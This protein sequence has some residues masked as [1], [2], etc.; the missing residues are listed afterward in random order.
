MENSVAA[1]IAAYRWYAR[2]PR[3]LP[4]GAFLLAAA[5]TAL[6][7]FAI[8]RV[9][10]QAAREKVAQVAE[11]VNVALERRISANSAYLLAGAAYISDRETVSPEQFRRFTNQLARD[12]DFHSAEGI[13]WGRMLVRG[14]EASFTSAMRAQGYPDY[15][16]VPAGGAGNGVRVPVT[17]LEPETPR[18][19][20][21]IG[22]DLYSEPVR[23]A[24]MDLAARNNTPT[25][26]GKL[27]LVQDWG[28]GNRPGFIIF[29][30]VFG[31]GGEGSKLAGFIYS[32]FT[33]QNVLNA[34]LTGEQRAGYSIRLFDGPPR[35]DRL[36]AQVGAAPAGGAWRLQQMMIA[37]RQMTLGVEAPKQARLS[38]LSLLTLLFG[39]IAGG[40]ILLLVRLITRQAIADRNSLAWFE[41]QASIRNSL[42]RELNHR[43][44]NTLANVL[45]IISLTRRRAANLDDFSE[46]LMG[47]ISALSATHDL[48][49]QS[50][51]GTTPIRAV[52][53]AEL[54]PYIGGAEGTVSTCG[55]DIEIAPNDA[56][57]LG[58]ALHELATNASKYGALSVPSGTV[59]VRWDLVTQGLA[60][61][62]W[63][64]Q[65]GPPVA[66][67]NRRGFGTELIE[68]IVAHELGTAVDL[69]FDPGGV[70]CTLLVPVRLP[71][72]FKIRADPS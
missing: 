55:I 59:E 41:E 19:R 4:S 61:V 57:S 20:V 42:T 67:E 46:A 37:G 66:A 1:R 15:R 54:A 29:M 25:A 56:L 47:R 63:T 34:A 71:V 5:L 69:R 70:N 53:D 35:T 8:E 22:F 52:V 64:E 62:V 18:N 33:A 72:N 51:W 58:L 36:L 24:A 14:D 32:A 13:G 60:R 38:N 6:S 9:E 44:K 27:V 2:F 49:T 17:F 45:S 43:V 11:A 48:L 28:M 30:P 3:A 40:L 68:K 26:T 50:E 12:A 21:A 10:A 39:L 16:I 31:Q 65:G 23:R 7:V